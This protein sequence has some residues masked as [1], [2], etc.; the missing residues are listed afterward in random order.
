MNRIV[1]AA[2]AAALLTFC[3]VA[4]AC[5]PPPNSDA[6]AVISVRSAI[7][8]ADAGSGPPDTGPGFTSTNLKLQVSQNFCSTTVAQDYFQVTNNSGSPVALSDITIKFWINDTSGIALLSHVWYGGCVTSANG[9]CLHQVQAVTA[10][11]TQFSP[12]CGPDAS[13]QANWEI[14]VTTTDTTVLAPGQTWSNLQTGI[15]LTNSSKFVPGS[16]TWFS[17]CGTGKAFAPNTAFAVYDQGNLVNTLGVTAPICRSPIAF[18][19]GTFITQTFYTDSDIVSSFQDRGRQIDC[20]NFA[21]QHSVKALLAAGLPAPSSA[22]P[23]PVASPAIPPPNLIG[24]IGYRGQLDANG[25]PQSCPAGTIPTSRPTVAEIQAAGG[26]AQ[27]EALQASRPHPVGGMQAPFEHDCW[28]N[29][30]QN[31][32]TLA[33]QPIFPGNYEHAVGVQAGGWLGASSAGYFGAEFATPIYTSKIGD[34]T[35]GEHSDSQLWV[36]TGTC[37][38][39]WNGINGVPSGQI[40]PSTASC[41]GPSCAVQSVESGVMTEGSKTHLFVYFTPNGYAPTGRGCYAGTRGT[42][43]AS[44]TSSPG[45]P[46]NPDCWVALSSTTTADVDLTG[47]V[48][49]YGTKPEELD[50]K[51]VNGST[52][53]PPVPGWF[54]YVGTEAVGYYPLKTFDWDDGTAGPLETGPATYLQAGGEV[55]DAW[56]FGGHTTTAMVSD[57]PAQE[58]FTYAAYARNVVYYDSTRT[59]FDANLQFATTPTVP[60]NEGD[61]GFPGLCGLDSAGWTDASGHLGGYSIT[62]ALPPGAPAWRKYFYFGGGGVS[63]PTSAGLTGTFPA[64]VAV[65]TGF[66]CG[67]NPSGGV[68]CWGDGAFGDLGNGSTNGSLVPAPVPTLTNAITSVSAGNAFACAVTTGTQ[69]MCWGVAALGE[70]G[71]NGSFPIP[72][73]FCSGTFVTDANTTTASLPCAKTP[74]PVVGTDLSPLTGFTAVSAGSDFACGLTQNGAVQCWGDNAYGAI[75]N[76]GD[77]VATGNAKC[78]G[79]LLASHQ[80]S[81]PCALSP[82]AVSNLSSGVVSIAAGDNSACAVTSVGTV[83]CWGDNQFGQL[84]A[85]S[86][87]TCG[88]GV[89]PFGPRPCSLVPI[90]VQGIVGTAVSV[91]VGGGTACAVTTDGGVWCWGN[92]TTGMLGIASST[93]TCQGGRACAQSGIH[94]PGLPSGATAVSVGT[95]TACALELGPT[96]G[97]WCWGNNAVAAPMNSPLIPD[98][99]DLSAGASSACAL[100]SDGTLACW[101]SN[102]A[103]QLGNRTQTSS[104]TPVQAI[105]P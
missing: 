46:M 31:N 19:I 92:N 76:N 24:T 38:N 88:G 95:Q 97:V 55:Y 56:Q 41:T 79:L 37:E 20:I 7:T 91:S 81:Y 65:G 60:A 57:R 17:P 62:A 18:Q 10:T 75:G 99:I 93:T 51:I 77:T 103:G 66:A 67:L 9:S 12:A 39:W 80:P 26:I 4:L 5:N 15:N 53:T 84:G 69:I 36:Q 58:G 30:L 14:A 61:F 100:N 89:L 70:L 23:A 28:L 40:C 35:D 78:G 82:V 27:Y 6:A 85:T 98:A 48:Q 33:S 8:G 104:A 21:A 64:P 49:P 96:G 50:L 63:G 73:P 42:C 102:S 25:K 94:V 3:A 90:Q 86:T 44:S 54:I 16:Q 72:E 59:S 74:T 71:N 32:N 47:H 45:V 34:A 22:P 29:P 13:H 68:E 101:G 1:S 43:C 11:P 52:A 87:G 83:L 2:K 105:F